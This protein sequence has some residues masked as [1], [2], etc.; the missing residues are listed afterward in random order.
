M[1]VG[2]SQRNTRRSGKRFLVYDIMS[3]DVPIAKE[4][5]FIDCTRRTFQIVKRSIGKFFFRRKSK[6]RDLEEKRKKRKK[7]KEKEEEEKEE[8][9][10]KEKK[11]RKEKKKEEEE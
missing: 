5:G 11:K 6:G 2:Q 4:N 8:E 7:K 9:K 1:E 10:K 3:N